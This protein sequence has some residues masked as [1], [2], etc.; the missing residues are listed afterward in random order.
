VDEKMKKWIV[1]LGICMLMTCSVLTMPVRASEPIVR[2]PSTPIKMLPVN[3]TSYYFDIT[4]SGVP[5][6]YDV[7]DGIYHGW[8]VQKDQEMD[9]GVNHSVTLRSSL[10]NNLPN[11][12][13]A[14]SWNDINY[15]IN[16]KQAYSRNNIQ[17]AIWFFTDNVNLTGYPDAQALVNAALAYNGSYTPQPGDKLAIPIVGVINIQLSFLELTIPI[18]SHFQGLV[19]N[20]VNKN[21]RQNVNV[22]GI[23][24]V[25]VR[26]YKSTGNLS[27]TTTTNSQ[28]IYS[29]ANVLPG[30]YY[31]QFTLPSGYKFSPQDAGTDDTL[32]SDADTSGKTIVFTVSA[33]ESITMWDAGMYVPSSGGGSTTTPSTNYP[34]SANGKGPYK[35]FINTNITFNGSASYDRD[36]Q[37]ITWRWNFGDG[38]GTGKITTHIYTAPGNYT[39]TLLVTDNKFATDV[40]TTYANIT[41][42]NHPP[43]IPILTG[44]ISGH[45]NISSQ[46]T[47]VST[48]PDG[49]TLRYVIDWGDGVQDTSP[50]VASGQ[51]IQ[52]QHQ[53]KSPGFYLVQVYAQEQNIY[54]LKSDIAKMTIAIDVQY[55]GNLGYFIDRN[56]DGIFDQYHNNATGTET[57]VSQQTN[58]KYLLD[59]N[60]DGSYDLV[61]DTATGQT[62]KYTEQPWLEYGIIILVIL[63]IVALLLFYFLRSRKQP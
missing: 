61:Y 23:N 45:V 62:Q 4:L 5:L 63:V 26:L 44:P 21:G 53:W 10:E 46:Y 50:A 54:N 1:A 22:Q 28:G 60:G 16:H 2:L 12:F 9:R 48:D 18:P 42:G 3:G 8:C 19:W 25:M 15:I 32:D 30:D 43:T 41:T 34:P 17:M 27:Q 31:L 20:D 13:A 7:A 47:V 14:I 51:S 36:G 38:N 33:N 49:D 6:G 24:N 39:V 52:P 37:I 59:S 11:G 56:G 58:G 40:Y 57:K 35:G 55:A 29:F